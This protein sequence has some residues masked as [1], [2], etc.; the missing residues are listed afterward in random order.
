[1]E[2]APP[3]SIVPVPGSACRSLGVVYSFMHLFIH[4]FICLSVCLFACLFD[5]F[6]FLIGFGRGGLGFLFRFGVWG[7][8]LGAWD[9]CFGVQGLGVGC[10]VKALGCRM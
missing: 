5:L 6:L 10:G 8:G 3:F 9:L 4:L 7:L 1:M 2:C